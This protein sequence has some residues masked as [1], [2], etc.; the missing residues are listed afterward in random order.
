MMK[1]RSG[2]RF[3]FL[4]QMLFGI[5]LTNLAYIF[6]MSTYIKRSALEANPDTA[7]DDLVTIVSVSIAFDMIRYFA[8]QL[9]MWFFAFK[10][11]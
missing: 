2:S 11:W 5:M 8:W 1:V 3:E 4:T 10:Y 9:T 6:Y 7:R